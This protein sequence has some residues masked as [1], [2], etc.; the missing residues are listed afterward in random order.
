MELE[1][2]EELEELQRWQSHLLHEELE[3]LEELQR[4]QSHLLRQRVGCLLL[5]LAGFWSE[6]WGETKGSKCAEAS[7]SSMLLRPSCCK[8]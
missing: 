5:A 4:W 2:L 1:E 8:R 3:E 7:P 6:L